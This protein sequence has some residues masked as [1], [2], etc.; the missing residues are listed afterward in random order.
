MHSELLDELTRVKGGW[1]EK[2]VHDFNPHKG[3]GYYPQAGLTLDAQGNLFGTTL[4]CCSSGYGNNGIVFKLKP[5]AGGGWTEEILHSFVN[6]GVQGF[7]PFAGVTFD[8]AAISMER[9]RKVE[10]AEE[11][12]GNPCPSGCGTIFKLSPQ[13]DG[14]WSQTTLHNFQNNKWDG[15]YPDGTLA[16]DV[17]GN[18]YGTTGTGGAYTQGTVFKLTQANGVWNQTI[19]HNFSG[20]FGRQM[21]DGS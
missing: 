21:P 11:V 16:L 4:S 7:S 8:S 3:D 15:A 20:E 9:R 1:V 14:S 2:T 10:L 5:T 13:P 17:A 19:L 18:I 6:D 12:A